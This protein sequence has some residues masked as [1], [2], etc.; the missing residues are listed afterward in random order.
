MSLFEQAATDL[1]IKI[2]S[3]GLESLFSIKIPSVREGP[4]LSWTSVVLFAG[5]QFEG[6]V[7]LLVGNSSIEL[8]EIDLKLLRSGRPWR[9]LFPWPDKDDCQ[10]ELQSN[11]A[12]LQEFVDA[13]RVISEVLE[14]IS[15]AEQH[16]RNHQ[17]L[18]SALPENK[19]HANNRGGALPLDGQESS[20]YQDSSSAYTTVQ[21][22][23]ND[24]SALTA[25]D[26]L[27]DSALPEVAIARNDLQRAGSCPE[28]DA[29]P[30]PRLHAS[31]FIRNLSDILDD[32]KNEAVMRW[33]EN[34]QSVFVTP[35]SKFPAHILAKLSTKSHQSVIRRL[36]YYG[37]HKTGSDFHHESFSRGQPSSI[38]P[39]QK[40]SHSPSRPSPHHNASERGPRYK[41]IKRKRPRESV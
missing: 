38:G 23:S 29:R 11:D 32:P 24:R 21:H 28:S 40:M 5:P 37:F 18:V 26:E 39:N 27:N 15:L 14:Q 16:L 25:N 13:R 22:A 19:H 35:E 12:V 20:G 6:P 2:L 9:F 30:G 4:P 17:D 8:S 31:D 10:K 33:P 1:T 7:Q 34:G 36:Y 41:V 3:K